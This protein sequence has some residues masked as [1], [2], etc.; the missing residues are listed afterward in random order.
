[1]NIYFPADWKTK[2]TYTEAEQT[3]ENAQWVVQNAV[4]GVVFGPADYTE[5]LDMC[6]GPNNRILRA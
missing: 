3:D 2:F 5:C 1:M 6:D 4:H